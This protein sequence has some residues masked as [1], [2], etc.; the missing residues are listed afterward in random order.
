MQHNSKGGDFIPELE[1]GAEQ[2]SDSQLETILREAWTHSR[3]CETQIYWFTS[4]FDAVVA[5]I[6][7]FMKQTCCQQTNPNLMLLIALFGLALSVMG[8]FILMALSLGHQ[9]YIMNVIVILHKMGKT[10]YYIDWKKPVHYKD[11]HRMFFEIAIGLFAALFLFYGSHVWD[12]L[13]AFQNSAILIL[14]VSVVFLHIEAV[15]R[16]TWKKHFDKRKD[17]IL[18][19][20]PDFYKEVE[21]C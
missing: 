19:I 5:V 20:H 16:L 12:S 18:K 9:N 6:L 15:Y 21:D 17:F 11:F 8:F 14:I 4:I 3:H 7:V 13:V 1:S 10:R 2:E